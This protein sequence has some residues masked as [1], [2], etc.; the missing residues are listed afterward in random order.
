[1]T[2]RINPSDYYIYKFFSVYYPKFPIELMVKILQY[3][4]I[5]DILLFQSLTKD[6]E[7]KKLEIKHITNEKLTY[8]INC[9]HRFKPFHFIN[10]IANVVA[11]MGDREPSIS[12]RL[13]FKEGKYFKRSCLEYIE[14]LP[15]CFNFE[16]NFDELRYSKYDDL[17]SFIDFTYITSLKIL[18]MTS[19]ERSMKLNFSRL[20]VKSFHLVTNL[21]HIKLTLPSFEDLTDL[22]IDNA[23]EG[24]YYANL[25]NLK[26]F[27]IYISKGRRFNIEHVPRGVTELKIVVK[28][29]SKS[30]NE[31]C[32]YVKIK[33]RQDWPIN[34]KSL[35]LDDSKNEAGA[36]KDVFGVLPSNLIK[37]SVC[38]HSFYKFS[39]QFPDSIIDLHLYS[40]F[41]VMDIPYVDLQFPSSL[42]N[43]VFQNLK[44]IVPNKSYN[45]PTRLKS[46]KLDFSD[47]SLSLNNFNFDHC[48]S[49]LKNLQISRYEEPLVFSNLNFSEFLKLTNIEL[50]SCGIK[51]LSHFKPPRCLKTL[52]VCRNPITT[53]DETCDLFNNENG[54]PLLQSISIKGCQ[55]S[56][57]SPNIEWP[58]NLKSLV[59]QDEVPKDFYFN[60]SIAKHE[61]LETLYLSVLSSFKFCEVD[62][63]IKRK[64]KIKSFVL[65]VTDDFLPTKPYELLKFYDKI[66]L[67]LG[68][69]VLNRKADTSVFENLTLLLGDSNS[70]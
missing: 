65:S 35:T 26:T 33:S 64:T 10:G 22:S 57:I 31:N 53:I 40:T 4:T 8:E 67:F 20:Y 6:D 1:M 17:I 13:D 11:L 27:G 9:K 49:S 50:V 18:K 15:S 7:T 70:R 44:M 34:L 47:L 23:F 30:E 29:V 12:V 63:A 14:G 48:K 5:Q 16:L 61:S 52:Q 25:V 42:E 21:S 38:G 28:Y 56:F 39:S 41:S 60:T 62:K 3:T 54:C 51:S 37:F 68:K 69:R 19:G 59:I 58:I 46:F 55:I 24:E 36:F 66:H 45:L 32:E 43:I 2:V